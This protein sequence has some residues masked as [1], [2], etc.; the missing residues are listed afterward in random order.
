M[1]P[2]LIPI[3]RDE[4]YL[5]SF[6]HFSQNKSGIQFFLLSCRFF[7]VASIIFIAVKLFMF[8]KTIPGIALLM[9]E[10]IKWK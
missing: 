7:I 1:L 10:Q 4:S 9:N 5:S 3:I 2:E 8:F 6:A